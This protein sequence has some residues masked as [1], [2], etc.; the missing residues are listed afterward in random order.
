MA[1]I[2]NTKKCKNQTIN[3]DLTFEPRGAINMVI[4]NNEQSANTDDDGETTQDE[5]LMVRIIIPVVTRLTNLTK[6]KML[7][8][9]L[10][11]QNF[12]STQS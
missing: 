12:D 10:S 2:K 3:I 1:E 4:E 7:S 8:N 11:V 5:I 9:H 6:Q